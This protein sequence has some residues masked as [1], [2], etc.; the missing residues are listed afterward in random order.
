MGRLREVDCG[1][2]TSIGY[3]KTKEDKQDPLSTCFCSF[4]CL[5]FTSGMDTYAILPC[6]P[7]LLAQPLLHCSSVFSF[8]FFKLPNSFL[9]DV[10]YHWA[11]CIPP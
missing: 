6:P 5:P 10:C 8:S 4:T 9:E 2:E 3:L 7:F 11:L 1:L